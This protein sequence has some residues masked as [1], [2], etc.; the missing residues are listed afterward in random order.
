MSTHLRGDMGFVQGFNTVLFGYIRVWRR[1][2]FTAMRI[3]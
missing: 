3:L 1:V 2:G